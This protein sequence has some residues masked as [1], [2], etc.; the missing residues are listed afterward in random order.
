MRVLHADDFAGRVTFITGPGRATGKTSLLN[1]ALAL[2]R[3]GGESTAI[4]GMGFDGEGSGARGDAE[5]LG[6][7][8]CARIRVAAGEL[9]VSAE[10][11]LDGS[12]LCPE[13]LAVLPGSSALGRLALVRARRA[14]AIVLVGPEGNGMAAQAI[15]IARREFGAT[16]AVVDGAFNRISQVA[17]LPGSRFISSVRL[18]AANLPGLAKRMRLLARLSGLPTSAASPMDG[19]FEVRG[20][21]T[22][23]TIADIP[24]GAPGVIVEDFTKV[25]LDEGE[26]EAFLRGRDLA[27]RRYVEFRGFVLVLQG[28]DERR[29]AELLGPGFPEGLLIRNPYE[30]VDDRD[31]A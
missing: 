27:V 18:D 9:F 30:H 28:V 3:A 25:F 7:R 21:L 8:G 4:L 11:W 1:A 16:S 29:V 19:A 22:A 17:V 26:L 24:T 13:I 20:P 23:T 31:A 14:G 2:L 15:D 6:A 12:T 10:A 5:T